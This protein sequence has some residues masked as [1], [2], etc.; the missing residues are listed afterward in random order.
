MDFIVVQG[1]IA[2]QYADALVSSSSS[3]LRMDGGAARALREKAGDDIVAAASEKAPVE[4]GSVAVTD[5][6]D[7]HATYV[8]HA[9]TLGSTELSKESVIRQ[10]TVNTLEAAD[11]HECNSLV[12]PV[13]GAGIGNIPRQD[14]ARY[15]IEEIDSYEPE[16]LSDVRIIGLTSKSRW[17]ITDVA[18]EV[19]YSPST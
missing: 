8:I 11:K 17:E 19:R 4:P 12:F 7:L 1:D 13:L 10:A 6:F 9:V 15:I 3:R 16:V 14:A 2:E 18:D 5:G